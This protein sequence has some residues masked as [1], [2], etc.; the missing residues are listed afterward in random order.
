VDR[1]TLR[2]LDPE[3]LNAALATAGFAVEKQY[4]DFTGGALTAESTSIVTLARR[5]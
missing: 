3:R 5:V 1:A 2:F 4:G